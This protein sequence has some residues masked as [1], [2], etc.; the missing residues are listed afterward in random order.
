ML[1]KRIQTDHETDGCSGPIPG[2]I[3][4]VKVMA[5][6]VRH[7]RIHSPALSFDILPSLCTTIVKCCLSKM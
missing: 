5:H 1:S 2:H 4:L 6:S 7:V 3:G